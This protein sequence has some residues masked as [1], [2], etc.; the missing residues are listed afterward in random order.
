MIIESTQTAATGNR[1][2]ISAEQTDQDISW[3]NTLR[4]HSFEDF[5][6]QDAVKGKI[7]IFVKA[8]KERKEPLD[9]VLLSGPPG[10]GRPP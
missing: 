3:E 1:D 5:A 4:P 7:R 8:A 10:L 2:E 6:G 9:H